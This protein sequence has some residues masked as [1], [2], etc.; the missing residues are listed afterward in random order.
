MKKRKAS[1]ASISSKQY[2]VRN[3]AANI[4]D[5]IDDERDNSTPHTNETQNVGDSNP[6]NNKQTHAQSVNNSNDDDKYEYVE[7]SEITSGT[8]GKLVYLFQEYGTAILIIGLMVVC[9]IVFFLI[10]NI[11]S[12]LFFIAFALLAFLGVTLLRSAWQERKRAKE[13]WLKAET[14]YQHC[15]TKV[16]S[17]LDEENTMED[18]QS[19]DDGDSGVTNTSDTK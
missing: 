18:N 1:N 5:L 12:F 4:G 8:T 9:I 2:T 7:L 15:R 10:N 6:N 17:Q 14:I 11:N 16:N 13:Q 19:D 3:I